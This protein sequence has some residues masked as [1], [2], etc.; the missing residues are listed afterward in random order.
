MTAKA[1]PEIHFWVGVFVSQPAPSFLPFLLSFP[2][3]IEV[4]PQ[5]QLRYL[6]RLFSGEG[7]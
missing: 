3:A 4:T 5:A 2:A 1:V 7:V 6:L